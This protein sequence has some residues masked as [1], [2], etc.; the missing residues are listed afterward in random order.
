MP[1]D[2][3]QAIA[4]VAREHDLP[5]FVHA[6]N[7][8]EYRLAMTVKPRAIL[9]G[10][11]DPIPEGDPLLEQ[12]VENDIAVVPTISLFESFVR[13]DEGAKGWEDPVLL[14]SVPDFLLSRMKR[15]EFRRVEREKFLEV[16]RMDAYT[17]AEKKIPI[18]KDNVRKMHRAGVLLAVGTDAGGPVG[19]NFQGFNTPWEIELLV[20]CGLSPMEALVAATRHGAEVIGA[21]EELGTL[22]PGKRGD[23]LILD[24]NPLEDVRN[25][26]AIHTVILG[27]KPYERGELAFS[28]L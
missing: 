18:I 24:A 21:Q 23:M 9:H 20:E 12:L 2:I 16:A 5:I 13:F 7:I 15:P 25:I 28:E 17:W 19:Y 10:L 3:L 27:G 11:E 1:R 26:R 4:A 14:G 6:I 8:D 22:E